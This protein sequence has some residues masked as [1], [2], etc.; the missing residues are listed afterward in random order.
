MNT[1]KY[2]D[3]LFDYSEFNK[4]ENGLYYV[5]LTDEE[6][7]EPQSPK[8]MLK[9]LGMLEFYKPLQE[10]EKN[11]KIEMVVDDRALIIKSK[12]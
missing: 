3:E 5:S 9:V 7:R 11:D 10:L 4:I 2:L 12:H 1:N 8:G 6:T